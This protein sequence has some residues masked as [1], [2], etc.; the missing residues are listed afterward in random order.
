MSNTKKGLSA[1]QIERDLG[2]SYRTAWYLCH[3]I[4]KAMEE[5]TPGL[6]TGV[7]EADE[8][9]I[10]GAF[11][12]RRSVRRTTSNLFSEPAMVAVPQA[13]DDGPQVELTILN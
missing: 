10:G 4:R 13:V 3:R 11:D 7:V 5:G 9:H 8:T 6:L 2:V 1:K 12:R